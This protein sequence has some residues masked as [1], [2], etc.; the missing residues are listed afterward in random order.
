MTVQNIVPVLPTADLAQAV[1]L[2]T[3]LLGGAPTFVDGDRWAQFDVGGKR[4]ALAGADRMSDAAGVMIKVGDLEAAVA[5][6]RAAGL[7]P[8]P[9]ERGP[10]ERRCLVAVEG[11]AVVLY[12]AP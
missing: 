11:A 12:A 6:A 4:L 9:V 8:G 5:A 1:A 3:G 2:W 7:S 10:H